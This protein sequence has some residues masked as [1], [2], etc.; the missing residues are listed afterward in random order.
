MNH[1][2][3]KHTKDQGRELAKLFAE[4]SGRK[5]TF[6]QWHDDTLLL[7]VTRWNA[8]RVEDRDGKTL[9]EAHT[10][11]DPFKPSSYPVYHEVALYPED[12]NDTKAAVY[13]IANGYTRE[14]PKDD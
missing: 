10:H 9:R 11:D 5:V 13:M 1:T 7:C 8:M 12:W 3:T 2:M 6:I 4:A 14:I